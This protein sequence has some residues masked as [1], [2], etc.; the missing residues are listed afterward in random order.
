MIFSVALSEALLGQLELLLRVVQ[1]LQ[2]P[3][4]EVA[5]H[6][7]Q[8]EHRVVVHRLQQL[9]AALT[10]R[11]TAFQTLSSQSLESSPSCWCVPKD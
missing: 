11:Q 7:V 9:P 6:C 5:P 1:A 8:L 3:Q 10:A 2:L 4:A